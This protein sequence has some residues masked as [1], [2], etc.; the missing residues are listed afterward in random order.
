L[1]KIDKIVV[2]KLSWKKQSSLL[3]NKC[4]N[5]LSTGSSNVQHSI[6]S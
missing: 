3:H 6:L 5:I 2:G 1:S 4:K